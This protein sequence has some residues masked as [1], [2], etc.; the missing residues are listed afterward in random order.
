M[1][2]IAKGIGKVGSLLFGGVAGLAGNLLGLGKSKKKN[3]E[4]RALIAQ[5]D[6]GRDALE[7]G[8][9]LRRRR[10]AAADMITGTRGAEAAAGSVGRLVV[11]A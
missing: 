5:R 1:G 8:D 6:E 2:F 3:I 9:A 4:P 10:G 11:G 7:A